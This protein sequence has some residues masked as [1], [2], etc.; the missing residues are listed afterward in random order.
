MKQKHNSIHKSIFNPLTQESKKILT[1][2]PK[3]ITS[4]CD[5][6]KHAASLKYDIRSLFYTLTND[7]TSRT[8]DYMNDPKKRNAYIH[9]YQWWN[10]VRL[11]KLF[12]AADIRI[13]EAAADFGSGPLTVVCALWIAKPELRKQAIRWYCTDISGAA[14][15]V[16]ED[17]FLALTAY[18]AK[19]SNADQAQWSIVKIKGTFGVSLKEKIS[20]ITT[21]NMFNESYNKK[22]GSQYAK[23]AA[24]T[25]Y[26][27]LCPSGS[28]FIIEPGTPP[29]A[30]FLF[31]MRTHF[32]HL[33]FFIK[34]PCPHAHVCPLTG[35][36]G[37][38]SQKKR[39]KWCHFSFSTDDAPS[40]L[41]SF[42]EKIN[43]PKKRASLS[44]LHVSLQHPMSES[45]KKIPARICSDIIRLPED[46]IGRY[47]CSMHGLLLI[48][49]HS[50]NSAAVR[51]AAFGSIFEY[52]AAVYNKNN[53]DKKSGAYVIETKSPAV[54][55]KKTLHKKKTR[56]R[57]REWV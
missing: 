1:A 41:Q 18:T 50:G 6:S 19:Y 9:Y 3:I 38:F 43:L 45:R 35:T 46:R 22:N 14:L 12:S 8:A 55:V 7:R 27:Y 47:A 44:F 13:Q 26:S 49:A 25:L 2:F 23:T 34:S 4:V 53:R 56:R 31:Y 5:I 30:E 57:K 24:E 48:T 32:L 16:G 42:S 39:T 20:F 54:S 17:I 37:L 52:S 40:N 10:L 28:I 33:N 51:A 15:A 21:A 11:V 36:A 29:A